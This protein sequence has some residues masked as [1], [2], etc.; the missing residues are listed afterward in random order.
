MKP[1]PIDNRRRYNR[2][3]TLSRAMLAFRDLRLP[4]MVKDLS[5]GGLSGVVEGTVSLGERGL[6]TTRLGQRTYNV[7][8]E[9]V[10]VDEASSQLGMRFLNLP[11][12]LLQRVSAAV[13]A[14]EHAA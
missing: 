6:L 5:V 7:P 12:G 11:Q 9:V 14:A 1:I 8:V 10:R 2:I 4:V 13:A 3:Q